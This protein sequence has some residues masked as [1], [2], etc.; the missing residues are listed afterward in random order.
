[1]ITIYSPY[2][3]YIFTICSLY[4]HYMF[5]TC[6]LYVHYHYMFTIT[7]CSLYVHYMFTI[8]SLYVHYMFIC[9]VCRGETT[10]FQDRKDFTDLISISLPPTF[11]A[12]KIRD[13]L[14]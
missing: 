5:T 4:V 11:M 6:S 1:M 14:W 10:G 12:G 7:I 8:C 3:H 2:V 13:H 9:F